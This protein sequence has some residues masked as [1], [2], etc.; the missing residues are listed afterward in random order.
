M[1]IIIKSN[2]KQVIPEPSA[3]AVETGI[4]PRVESRDIYTK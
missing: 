3:G 4:N 2:S 1:P